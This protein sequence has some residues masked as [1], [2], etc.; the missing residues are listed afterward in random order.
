MT[1]TPAKIQEVINTKAIPKTRS[2][3][4]FREEGTMDPWKEGIVINRAGKAKGKH[5]AWMNVQ[6]LPTGEHKSVNFDLVEWKFKTESAMI[7][8]ISVHNAAFAEAMSLEIQNLVDNEVFE[9]INDDGQNYID[10]K[11]DFTEKC[12]GV[13]TN[14]K[15]RLVAKGFQEDTE[16][17][18]TAK[19]PTCEPF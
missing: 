4:K 14:I 6:T 16:D 2:H 19:K 10:T 8:N 1:S 7:T 9:E 3:I 17:I 11:W 12:S 5:K 18:R 13:E 15:A